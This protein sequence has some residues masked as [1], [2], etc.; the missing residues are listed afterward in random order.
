MARQLISS[1]STFE[2]EIGYSRAVVDGDWIFVSGTTGYD[3]STMALPEGVVEQCE[4]CFANIASALGKAGSSLADVVR[5]NYILPDGNDFKAC[6]PVLRK[7]F[8]EVRPAATMVIA[9]LLDP[10]MKIEVEVTARRRA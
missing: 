10:K 4:N 5:V 3:Y 8:G 1:G 7:H 9:G 2:Q 6:W